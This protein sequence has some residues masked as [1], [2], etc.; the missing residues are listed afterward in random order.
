MISELYHVVVVH[1]SWSPAGETHRRLT[2]YWE[3]MGFS[4]HQTQ[5]KTE[6]IFENK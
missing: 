6:M 2:G 5:L 4:V 1:Q 3:I